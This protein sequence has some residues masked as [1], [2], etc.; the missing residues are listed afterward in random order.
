VT[1]VAAYLSG[2]PQRVHAFLYSG[3]VMA[4][5]GALD[6]L[7]SG[8]LGINAAGQVVGDSSEGGGARG[9]AVIYTGG[10]MYDLN[11]LTSGR[12]GFELQRANAINDAGQIVGRGSYRSGGR[13]RAFLLTPIPPP[14]DIR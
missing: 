4:D 1:G 3:G 11:K 10:K 12:H 13:T 8:G 14:A 7:A 9:V 6:G 2:D 5:L